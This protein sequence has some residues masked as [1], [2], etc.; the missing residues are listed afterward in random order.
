MTGN[1]DDSVQPADDIVETVAGEAAIKGPPKQER[2]VAEEMH[3][4]DFYYGPHYG[5]RMV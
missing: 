5:L 3:V 1:K 4:R 2:N